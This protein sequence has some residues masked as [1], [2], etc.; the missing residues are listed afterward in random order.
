MTFPIEIFMYKK[1]VIFGGSSRGTLVAAF[2]K[3]EFS[4]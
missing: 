1:I 2:V 4:V 3:A